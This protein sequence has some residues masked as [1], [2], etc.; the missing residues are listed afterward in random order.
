MK[1]GKDFIGVGCGAFIVN[2]KDEVLLMKCGSKS[3]NRVGHW[4]IPGGALDYGECFEDA[5]KREIRE[6]LGIE[7]EVVSLLVLVDDIIH[8]EGEHWITS[9]YHAKIISGEPKNMEPGKC[10]ALQWFPIDALP[11][12]ITRL[13]IE[14][15][16]AYLSRKNTEPL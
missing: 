1:P 5:V 9:Q 13:S 8:N 14:A 10:D 12:P 3:K 7:I 4:T 2:E 11:E 6:E 16:K 15:A